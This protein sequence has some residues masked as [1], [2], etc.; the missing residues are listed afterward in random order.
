MDQTTYNDLGLL[1]GTVDSMGRE[2]KYEYYPNKQDVQYVKVKNGVNWD[3]LLTISQYKTI[4]GQPAHLPEI[5]TDASGLEVEYSYNDK[6]Q[7]TEMTVSKGS[8]SETTR[9]IYDANLDGTPDAYGY[10]IASEH[11]SPSNPLAFVTL[12]TLTYDSA[13]RVRT[14]TDAQGYTL[15]YDYDN[16]DRVTLVTHP[17]ATTEQFVYSDGAKQTLDVWAGKDRAGRW[18]RMRYNQHRQ[19]LMELDPLLRLT[20]YDW[21]KCGSL[22]KL[23]DPLGKV[24][25]WKR[26]AQGRVVE[27]LLADGNQYLYVYQPLSGRLATVA[28]PKDVLNATTTVTYRHHLDGSVQKKDYTDGSMADVTYGARDFVGRRTSMADLY[29]TTSYAY[30][31]LTGSLNGSGQL[32]SV[33]GSGTDDTL[34]YSYDWRNRLTKSEVVNDDGVTVTRA[35]EATLDSLGRTSQVVNNLGTFTST[36]NSGN[37]TGLPDQVDLPG[38]FNTLYSRYAPNAGADALRLQTIHHRQ[39]TSTVQKHDYSYALTGDIT[40]W[41]R[42]NASANVTSWEIRHDQAGQLSEIDETLDGVPQKKEAWHYDLAG[43]ISS[44]VSLPAVGSGSLQIRSIQGRNQLAAVGGP[45]TT[46]VEG[47]IDEAAQVQVNGDAAVVT[48]LGPTGP[49]KFQKEVSVAAGSNAISVEATDANSNVKTNNYTLTVSAGADEEIEYDA[50]GNVVEQR[51]GSGVVTRKLEWDAQNQLLAVQSAATPAVGVKRSEFGYDGFGRRVRLVEKE[52]N[53]TTWVVLS[54]WNYV[55]NGLELI[56][57]R[58][59]TTNIASAT[60]FV[61]G[62]SAGA[63][64]LIYLGDHLGSIRAWFRASDGVIGQAEFSAYGERTLTAAG[65]GETERGYTGHLMHPP[66]GLLLAPFRA[67]N[68][69]LGRWIS[70]D[71]IQEAGGMNL[72]SYVENAPHNFFDP[73][74]LETFALRANFTAFLVGLNFALTIDHNNNL[75]FNTTLAG[76]FSAGISATA[77]VTITD[78]CHVEQLRGLGQAAGVALGEGF[79]AEANWVWGN[80]YKGLDL[81]AGA[82]AGI[83]FTPQYFGG[84]TWGIPLWRPNR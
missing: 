49:W 51:D 52:H 81:G 74:G 21:C 68:P 60:Y 6:G 23:I 75:D 12:Q 14:I 61:G 37:L 33:N 26:D 78:A 31:S 5:L 84:H 28:F 1:T 55:W 83:P 38:G 11:T 2:L 48:K 71:P 50:N 3:T 39:G 64:S 16:L 63:D 44:T 70:E 56:Q 47:T 69:E 18:T 72:Y 43:N 32:A 79:V 30:L 36:Y 35:E 29:G 25:T 54:E 76:G 20:Q 66:S 59:T 41:D 22:K 7:V 45:G 58:D 65:P 9:Y 15:T 46:L 24:T 57:K 53:G 13:K 42:T 8:N 27:K 40:T 82:G 19:L 80:G 17:D 4:G 62:E 73:F 34:R 10:L 77:G 67:Y